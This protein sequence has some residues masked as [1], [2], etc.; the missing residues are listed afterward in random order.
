MY[1][2]HTLCLSENASEEEEYVFDSFINGEDTDDDLKD[3]RTIQK[4]LPLRRH[5]VQAAHKRATHTP[6]GFTTIS[7]LVSTMLM[8]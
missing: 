3:Q 7:Q 1:K 6:N 4:T 2:S 5:G 8:S